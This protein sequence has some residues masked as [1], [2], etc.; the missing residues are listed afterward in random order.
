MATMLES[1]KFGNIGLRERWGANGSPPKTTGAE[2]MAH[3]AREHTGSLMFFAVIVVAKTLSRI[4][5][6]PKSTPVLGSQKRLGFHFVQI[7]TV[8]NKTCNRNFCA[9]RQSLPTHN[10][11]PSYV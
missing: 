7:K 11:Q 6:K 9:R 5:S 8:L 10:S 2:R 3:C 1:G 4:S